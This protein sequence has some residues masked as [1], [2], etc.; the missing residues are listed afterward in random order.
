MS[1]VRAASSRYRQS[2]VCQKRPAGQVAF[3]STSSQSIA[4]SAPRFPPRQ[5]QEEYLPTRV[6]PIPTSYYTA[7][8]TYI[9]SLIL[10][11][12]LARRTKRALQQAHIPVVVVADNTTKRASNY[13]L[14]LQ[15]LSTRLGVPLKSSQYRH[16]VARLVVLSRYLPSV[17]EH[18]LEGQAGPA[19]RTLAISIEETL[20]NFSRNLGK[21]EGEEGSKASA[22]DQFYSATTHMDSLGRAYARG[23]RKESSA[24]VW[25]VPKQVD[26]K[27]E[28]SSLLS[29]SILINL[30]SLPQTFTRVDH[31]EA[32]L[33][34]LRLTG[35]L[36]V[37][38]VFALVQGGG[39]TGQS[40]A[41]A[42]G[43]ARAIVTH[44]DH[45][46]KE[47]EEKEA[48]EAKELRSKAVAIRDILAK[49][50]VLIRDTRMVE[51]KKTGL[52]KARKAYTWVKR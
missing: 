18:F 19:N 17:T 29:Q 37:V 6:K 50:G 38:N 23:R 22:T 52:A 13:W 46:A 7:R 47:A 32:V 28:A 34:P 1:F 43:I 51:R 45:Q 35:L 4:P 36:G 26:D 25:V 20:R 39:P 42:H 12:D 16:I 44:F 31:R 27:T 9:D 41:I 3:A 11:E 10:L 30:Q 15:D 24:R 49:D 14:K 48:E 5:V 8:P 21:I 40:G 2:I 33:Y